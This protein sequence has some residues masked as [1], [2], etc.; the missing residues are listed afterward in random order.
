MNILNHKSKKYWIAK[1][2]KH[3]GME[4]IRIVGICKTAFISQ[5]L[6]L[7]SFFADFI[8]HKMFSNLIFTNLCPYLTAI[9]NYKIIV[10][11]C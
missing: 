2:Q 9:S 5:F 1:L 7:L 11:R 4:N 10:T 8:V 3:F 6:S